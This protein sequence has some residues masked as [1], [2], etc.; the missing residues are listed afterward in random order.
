MSKPVVAVVGRPNVGKSTLF[1]KLVGKRLAIVDDTPGVTRDRL[2]GDC[3]WNGRSFTVIDTGGLEP[4]SSDALLTEM[5]SQTQRAVNDADVIIFVAD[6]GSGI[7]A[8][9]EEAARMIKRS[10]KPVVLAINKCDSVGSPPAEIYDFY[11]LGLG[12]PMPIS[13]AHGHGTGDM[14]DEVVSLLPGE[15]GEEEEDK[16]IRIAIIGKPNVG[17]SSLVNQV[18]GDSRAIVSNTAGTTRD[19]TD[20]EVTVGGIDFILT[21]TAGIRRRSKVDN[22]IEKYSVMR[23]KAAIERSDVCVVIID[24]TEGFTEQDAKIAGEAHEQGKGIVVAVNKW[25]AVAKQTDTQ[26]KFRKSLLNGLSFMTYAEIVFI[27]AKTGSGVEKLF[28]AAADAYAQNSRRIPTGSLND[29]LAAAVTVSQPPSDKGKRLK[30]Y[31]ITQ[32]SACPPTFVCFVNSAEL[33]HY[34]YQRYIENRIRDAFGLRGT[35]VRFIIREKNGK[36]NRS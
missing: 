33:F 17:K 30:I 36:D 14:L 26:D 21:D 15:D 10:G 12:D 2:Y 19:T 16:R 1:N 6:V 11:A 22:S 9:D 18:C 31:Y 35:P 32:P 3:E 29:V 23:A 13:A 25:D 27:S 8:A 4:F 5:R 7:T 34:S 28:E 24:A 20:T